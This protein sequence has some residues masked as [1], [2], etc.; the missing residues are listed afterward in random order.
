MKEWFTIEAEDVSIPDVQYSASH[1]RNDG[2]HIVRIGVMPSGFEKVLNTDGITLISQ[3]E[4]EDV[5]SSDSVALESH[6]VRDPE[7]VN[8]LNQYDVNE[9]LSDD[10]VNEIISKRENPW[11]KPEDIESTARAVDNLVHISTG[12]KF[13]LQDQEFAQVSHVGKKNGNVTELPE[14]AHGD[15]PE[16]TTETVER[17]VQGCN[18]A[19]NALLDKALHRSPHDRPGSNPPTTNGNG[20]PPDWL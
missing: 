8:E 7:L 9:V 18:H 12:G 5:F 20:G 16:K 19:H 4:V 6:D 1:Y 11:E 15:C 2:N 3:D 17:K 10:Q 13:V 14:T